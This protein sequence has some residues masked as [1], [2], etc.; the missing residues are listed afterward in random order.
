[1]TLANPGCNNRKRKKGWERNIGTRALI[2]K[3]WS[4]PSRDSCSHY[5]GNKWNSS[6]GMLFLK[7]IQSPNVHCI[8]DIQ[9]G[10]H[11]RRITEGKDNNLF[12][13]NIQECITIFFLPLSQK[14]LGKCQ[15]RKS[16]IYHSNHKS[17]KP[18]IQKDLAYV[19]YRSMRSTVLQALCGA[20]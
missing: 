17:N 18:W 5:R 12:L 19:K 15:K 11:P 1:M 7:I 16:W 14:R 6:Y 4:S 3:Q 8:W 9:T 20:H 2:S 10:C 13:L